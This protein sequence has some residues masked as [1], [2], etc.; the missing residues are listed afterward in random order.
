MND[1]QKRIEAYRKQLPGLRER[2]LA[3]ALLLVVSITIGVTTTFAWVVLSRSPEVSGVSTSVA[4][5]GNL[6]IA[7]ATGKLEMSPE[8]GASM[9]GDSS[10][11]EGQSVTDANITWGN[12]INLSD[13]SYGLDHLVL[14]PA[15]LNTAALLTSP[16]YGAEYGPDGRITK[17]KSNF[18]Y[19]AWSTAEQKFVIS[20]KLGVRAVSSTRLEQ[21]GGVGQM[22]EEFKEEIKTKN[23]AAATRYTALGNEKKYMQS[24]ATMMG[25]FMTAKMNS[26]Q[27]DESLTNPDLNMED[28]E[29]LLAMYEG[30]SESFEL[31][32]EAMAALLNLGCFYISD[33]IEEENLSYIKNYFTKDDI[34]AL[35]DSPKKLRNNENE[36]YQTAVTYTTVDKTKTATVTISYG[37]KSISVTLTRIFEFFNDRKIINEDIVKLQNITSEGATSLKWKD[38]GLETIVNRLVDVNKCTLGADNTPIGSIGASNAMGY[39]SGTQEARITN[40]ILYRFEER[41][42]GRIVVKELSISAKVKRSGITI[43]ATVKANIQTTAPST[44]NLF[45][46]DFD[47]LVEEKPETIGG[48]VYTAED[49]FGLAVDF[50]VRTNAQAHWLVL[51]GNVLTHSEEVAAMGKDANGKE[52]ELYVYK[53]T[54]TDAEGNTN[55]VDVDV[56]K[57]TDGENETWR[58][59]GTH[60]DIDVTEG[61]APVR[62]METVTTVVGYEGENRVWNEDTMLSVNSTTQGGGSCY[63]YYADTPEDQ[64]RSLKLLGAMKVAFVDESGRKLATAVMDTER[65][66]ANSGKVIVPLVMD[67]GDSEYMGNVSITDADGKLQDKTIYG[68]TELTKNE[69]TRITAIVYLDGTKLTNSEVLAAADIKGQLNIQFGTYADD[70]NGVKNEELMNKLFRAT[71]SVSHAEFDYDKAAGPMT[72]D[73]ELT[74][75]GDQPS[76]VQ[77]YFIRQINATQG[78]REAIPMTFTRDESSGKWVASYTFTVPGNYVLQSVIVD[79]VERDLD[80]ET[81]PKVVVKGFAVERLSCDQASEGNHINVLTSGNSTSADIKL[82]FATDDASKLPQT[83]QGRFLKDEDGSAVNVDFQ[84]N[85]T[86]QEWSGTANFLTSGEYTLQ[87][88]VLNGEYVELPTSM[89][90]T[91]SITLGLRVVVYTTSPHSFKYAPSEWE[92]EADKGESKKNLKM[93]VKILDNSGE[94]LLGMSEVKLI[95]GMK[96]SFAKTMD[97]D[98]DWDGSYYSGEMHNAGPGIWQFSSVTVD[99]NIITQATTSPTFTVISPEPPKYVTHD[100]ASYQYAPNQGATMNVWLSNASTAK[101]K[102]IIV[103]VGTGA[104]SEVLSHSQAEADNDGSTKFLFNVPASDT[105]GNQDGNWKIKELII[106]DAFDSD[107]TAYTEEVPLVIDDF[108]EEIKGKVV[109]KATISFTKP[110]VTG[111]C[112]KMDNGVINFGKDETGKVVGAFMDSYTVSGISVT[113]KDFE[114]EPIKNLTE[115]KLSFV[116][117]NNSSTYG[118]YTSASLTNAMAD[119]NITW[120]GENGAPLNQTTFTQNGEETLQY[121]GSWT[122]E[123]SY[124]VG[125]TTHEY[126]GET[127][128]SGAPKFTVSSLTPTVTISKISPD[129]QHS[130]VT[131]GKKNKT[132]T[133]G[134]N[135]NTITIYPD[136]EISSDGCSG[137]LNQEPTVYLKLVG[138]GNASEAALVFTC[139][140]YDEVRLYYGS[141]SKSGTQTNAFTWNSSTGETISRFVGYNDAGSCDDS[142][143]AG[144]LTSSN[145]IEMKYN[146]ES[147]FVN[148]GSIKIINVRPK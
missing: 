96:G 114:D 130:T 103:N 107:G 98:L 29:N 93:Q 141:N 92:E 45:T 121:A 145:Q 134:V 32:A 34:Y 91:A 44:Y 123:F 51:E 33:N 144:T 42:G 68:I 128:L 3:V 86:T 87:F 122:T 147:Y 125:S 79:G 25:L 20:D 140:E 108:G 90:H 69:A 124:K 31:E 70:I 5:N 35:I 63:V 106:W 24:L 117:N 74:I 40:G 2:V 72:T 8:P 55:T 54:E 139:A 7:L 76:K 67:P 77:A 13:P 58:M 135:G 53:M 16:L 102:A 66:Y 52:V 142:K 100:T 78:S 136:S 115:V 14:R 88:L 41:T 118:G 60:R 38:A 120:T 126:K 57:V 143:P 15:Q 18:D 105:N 113:I 116:Y 119:F 23:L 137:S 111:N 46:N 47:A 110:T 56:Y 146:G 97:A 101:V 138:L 99:G 95:Y 22:H 28:I 89:W 94:E 36:T 133:S 10:A 65:F 12:M 73:V 21:S 131:D 49:T 62:K 84:L 30:F 1:T 39:L 75:D 17:L 64:A 132:V 82:K 109:C 71:A 43:P 26:T 83:V 19:T 112:Q 48:G 61:A 80:M 9:V 50:W 104:E 6:E 4:S 27:G 127:L 37:G 85:S 81:L 129:G 148:I 59:A 11:A